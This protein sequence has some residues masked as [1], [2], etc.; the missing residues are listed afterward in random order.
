MI[1]QALDANHEAPRRRD[2]W[3]R[4]QIEGKYTNQDSDTNVS[5]SESHHI[6]QY[7]RCIIQVYLLPDQNKTCCSCREDQNRW[8]KAHVEQ[9]RQLGGSNWFELFF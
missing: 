7:Q 2:I 1:I 8:Y 9:E 6:S 5:D 4:S 3:S